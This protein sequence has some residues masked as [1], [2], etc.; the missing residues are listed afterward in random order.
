[1]PSAPN[2]NPAR[3]NPKGGSAGKPTF[4]GTPGFKTPAQDA[5]TVKAAQAAASAQATY[6]YAN[7]HGEDWKNGPATWAPEAGFTF[8]SG[9]PAKSSGGGSGGGGVS[10]AGLIAAAQAA[11]ARTSKGV[12]DLYNALS[13]TLGKNIGSQDAAY[14]GTEGDI[15]G[16]YNALSGRVAGDYSDATARTDSELTRLGQS[17]ILGQLHAKSSSDQNWLQSILG[18]QGQGTHDS[19]EMLRSGEHGYNT[20]VTGLAKTEGTNRQADIKIALAN[21]IAAL[22]A[23]H[24]GGGGGGSKSKPQSAGDVASL[25]QMLGGTGGAALMGL[26]NNVLGSPEGR[27]GIPTTHKNADGTTYTT[28]TKASDNELA[29]LLSDAGNAKYD[30]PKNRDFINKLALQ[31]AKMSKYGP[32]AT[33]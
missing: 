27:L 18:A 9:T 1:M 28:Y 30:N 6:D 2:P 23:R 11:A 24:S 26:W 14:K 29:K 33:Q 32:G 15:T 5:A 7:T 20:A 4:G 17:G 8:G 12:G 3:G 25:A 19:L 21:Q 16:L 10:S 31:V 13:A 22:R